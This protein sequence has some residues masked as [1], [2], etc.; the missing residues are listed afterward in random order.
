MNSQF[1]LFES[2]HSL[3]IEAPVGFLA[4]IWL[5]AHRAVC[6]GMMFKMY[7]FNSQNARNWPSVVSKDILTVTIN[8]LVAVLKLH[9][10]H[11]PIHSR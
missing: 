6:I 9:F 5:V 3:K 7:V 4:G 11:F 1:N 10:S 2:G 8:L